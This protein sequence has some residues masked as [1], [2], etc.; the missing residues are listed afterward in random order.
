VPGALPA[1][2][3]ATPVASTLSVEPGP[4][5][6]TDRRRLLRIGLGLGLLAVLVVLLAACNPIQVSPSPGATTVA[7]AT[8]T[9]APSSTATPQ[10]TAFILHPAQLKADPISV[11]AWLFTP[12]YQA[13]LL[14]LV[15]ID[16]VVPDIGI[17]IILTTI[18]VRTVMVPLMRRQMVSMRQMQAIGPEVKEIQRRFKGDRLKAQQAQ[19]ALMKERGI[20]QAGCLTAMLPL[21]LILPMYQVVREG[22]TAA[23]ITPM[24]T[25]FGFKVLPVVC[26]PASL[27]PCLDPHIP[28][29][30]GINAAHFEGMIPLPVSLPILGAGISIFAL[31]YTVFQLIASR[32]AL[33]AH[34]PGVQLEQSARTQRTMAIWLPFITILYGS[35]IPVGVF[36]Y[37]IVS[38]LYQVIQ[39]FLTTGWGGMFPLFGWTPG[40]AVDHKPRFPV[41]MPQAPASTATKPRPAGVPERTKPERSA[42]D[43][44]ASA[45]STIRRRGRQGRR[46]RRR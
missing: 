42:I 12:I 1:A 46:G 30:G 41:A 7:E 44:G 28:W 40:F 5:P 36:L 6:L 4:A 16:L 38:T 34:T 3:P 21:L 32:L 11:L 23:D 45:E 14:L 25:I 26:D 35:V 22:L 9:P 29:L 20:S 18:V 13:F 43:R 24:L 10:P 19:A 2:I 17:A 31:V 8:A 33:P 39:Q 15:A 37:L 27:Q